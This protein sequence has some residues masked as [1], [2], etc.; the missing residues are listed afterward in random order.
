V[1][2]G[3]LLIKRPRSVVVTNPPVF[4]GLLAMVYGWFWRAPV[5][6]DS[7]PAAFGRKGSAAGRGLLP[8]HRWMVSRVAGSVVT[9]HD[10]VETVGGWGGEADLLHEAPGTWRVEPVPPISN[11][12]V[13][14]VVGIFGGDEP[15]AEV[16]SAAAAVPDIDLRLTGEVAR[17]SPQTAAAGAALPNVEFVGFLGP[18]DYRKAV[19]DAHVVLTLTTEPTSV[20]RAA[21]EAVFA[22]RPLVVTDWP[23]LREY[24]PYAVHVK[25]EPAAIA[26]G[27]TDAVA[28]L[29]DLGALAARAAEIQH[30]RWQ[31]QLATLRR[32]LRL[33]AP[34]GF[35][36]TGGSDPGLAVAARGSGRGA[37]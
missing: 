19:Y 17:L 9:T 6:L 29:D 27:M 32:R 5:V 15:V 16:L 36:S 28:R 13:V 30:D 33:P 4:P 14:L 35:T 2:V 22:G 18:D 11:R 8:V 34:D 3:Y 1:T 12:P 24:F 26:V 31:E 7:H 21:C 25:N 37:L 10:W 23:V 20:M